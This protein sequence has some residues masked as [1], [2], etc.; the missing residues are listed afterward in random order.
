MYLDHKIVTIIVVLRSAE[1]SVLMST[2]ANAS[3]AAWVGPMGEK[4]YCH[5][6]TYVRFDP[7][8]AIVVI[9][10]LLNFSVS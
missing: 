6:I 7:C 5:A 10:K 1:G 8:G 4:S 9:S 3:A 2:Q